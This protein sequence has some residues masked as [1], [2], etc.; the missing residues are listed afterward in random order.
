M[1]CQYIAPGPALQRPII[2]I[3]FMVP[4]Y[5]IVSF[6][7]LMFKSKTPYI[8]VIRDTYEA[9]VLYQT[10]QFVQLLSGMGQ[11]PFLSPK[12]P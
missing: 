8:V 7:S 9:F 12:E 2:R 6:M 5:A 11:V 10:G 3:L 1:H 4:I